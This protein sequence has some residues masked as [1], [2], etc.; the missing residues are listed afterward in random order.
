MK[1]DNHVPVATL[2][3]DVVWYYKR[4]REATRLARNCRLEEARTRHILA[5]RL[6]KAPQTIVDVGGGAG[7]YAFWLTSLGYRVH[8]VEPVALH[9]EQADTTARQTGVSLGGLRQADARNLPFDA[10]LLLGPLYHLTDRSER[11]AALREAHRVLRPGGMVFAAAIGRYSMAVD[12]FFRDLISDP[13][14]VET[15]RRS[16]RGGQ[17]RNPGRTSGLFTTSY[18]HRAEE[19]QE[20]V[21]ASGFTG[22]ELLA[23]EGA[24][25]CIPDF[26]RKWQDARFRALLME[27]IEQM[28]SD[29]S[30]V[31]LGGHIMAVG[32]RPG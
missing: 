23:I 18:F 28:E 22:I 8:L 10:A 21:A 19:L 12:G 30:V 11:I 9:L 24:W 16:T 20:E 13:S 2:D 14:F 5:R 27:T 17:H 31:G 1:N 4:G 29:L 15:M 7:A 3:P 6:P 26:E 32:R 25:P